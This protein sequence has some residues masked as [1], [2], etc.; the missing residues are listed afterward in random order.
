MISYLVSVIESI[1]C[2]GSDRR[3]RHASYSHFVPFVKLS[4]FVPI[5]FIGRDDGCFWQKLIFS[6]SSLWTFVDVRM[7]ADAE[8]Q[9]THLVFCAVSK[10][11]SADSHCLV[12]SVSVAVRWQIHHLAQCYL[13]GCGEVLCRAVRIEIFTVW[14]RALCEVSYWVLEY[15]TDTGSSC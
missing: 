11:K 8:R 9:A 7:C 15:L 2:H 6:T 12:T 4:S 1:S 10:T 3:D 5:Y 13:A 14:V